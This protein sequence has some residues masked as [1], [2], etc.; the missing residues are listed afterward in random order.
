TATE[1][2]R[3]DIKTTLGVPDAGEFIAS[4]DRENLMLSVVPKMDGL[5]QTLAFLAAHRDESGIIYCTTRKQVDTLTEQLNANGWQAVPYHAGLDDTT[6]FRHQRQF[7]HDEVP[8]V[9][10]TIAFGMGINKSNV[11]FILHYDLPKN[12]ESYY[13][14]IGR[15]G[16]DGLPAECQLLFSYRD[17]QTIQF[18]INQQEES[19]QRGARIR[20]D[21]ML[22]FVDTKLCRRRPLLDYLGET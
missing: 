18:L 8:L 17:V 9:V 13:Q 6:R 21:A 3:Q 7:T 16:R 11:R 22:G 4:F 19:Q 14:Q 1:R 20:L 12:L 5:A 2:V 10:A 15:A